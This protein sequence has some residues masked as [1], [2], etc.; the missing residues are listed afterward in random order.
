MESSGPICSFSSRRRSWAGPRIQSAGAR[1]WLAIERAEGEVESLFAGGSCHLASPL[2]EESRAE[3]DHHVVYQG[4]GVDAGG[5][6][7]QVAA[8]APAGGGLACK[9]AGRGRRH[10]KAAREPE[11]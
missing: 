5:L 11:E 9:E 6:K 1:T 8:T 3:P 7:E 10:N 2:I 4:V